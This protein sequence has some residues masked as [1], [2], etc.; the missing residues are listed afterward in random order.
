[1]AFVKFNSFLADLAT[2]GIHNLSTDTLKVYLT[3]ATPNPATHSVKSDIAE[4]ST[5]NGYPGP[6]TPSISSRGIVGSEYVIV[7]T[8]PIVWTGAGSGFGPLQHAIL[9][10]DTS[11]GDRLIGFWSYPTQ[12]TKIDVGETLTLNIST[13]S[14]LLKLI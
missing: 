5:G 14:G 8:G 4:I 6:A 7:P 12:I 11:S 3:N 10:N 13:S 2:G 9:F 1:M